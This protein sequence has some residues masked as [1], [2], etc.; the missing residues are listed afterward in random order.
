MNTIILIVGLIVLYNLASLMLANVITIT[1]YI[2]LTKQSFEDS[3][4]WRIERNE[5]EAKYIALC[6]KYGN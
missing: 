6:E 5:F 2:G 4:R 3:T 1:E